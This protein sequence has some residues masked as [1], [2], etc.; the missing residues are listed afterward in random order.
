[1]QDANGEVQLWDV[2][3]GRPIQQLGKVCARC[4]T[5]L[6]LSV[7]EGGPKKGR[8]AGLADIA[9]IMA[10]LQCACVSSGKAMKLQPCCS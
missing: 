10:C 4:N 1:M 6:A 9:G 2:L 3:A 7:G 8:A 5:A